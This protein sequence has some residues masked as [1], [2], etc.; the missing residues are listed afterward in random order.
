MAFS[1]VA[2]KRNSVVVVASPFP[3]DLLAGALALQAVLVLVVVADD[4]S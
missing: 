1:L 2:P 3:V 4:R